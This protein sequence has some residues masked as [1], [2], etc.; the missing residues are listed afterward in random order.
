MLETLSGRLKGV[1]DKLRQRGSLTEADVDSALREIRLVLL[2]A[3][4]NFKVVKDFVAGVRERAVG[5]EV[6]GS[7]TPGQQVVKVVNDE[8]TKLLGGAAARMSFASKPPTVVMLV[9]LQG[10]GKTTATAKLANFVRGQGHNPRLVAAD[11]YRPAAVDQLASLAKELDVPITVPT[12][13]MKPLEVAKLGLK[14]AGDSAAD[15]IIVDTAGRTHIDEQ[16]M[17]EAAELKRELRP[18][19][20][21][22]VVDA[23]TGQ[24]AVKIAESFALHVDFDGIILTKLDGDARGGAALS[25]RAVTGKPVVFASVGEKMSSLEPFHPD[26]M[27]SR[28]LGMG[29]VLTLI[30][31]AQATVDEDKAREM[32]EKLRRAEF[33]FEDFLDQLGQVRKMG[34]MNELL[35]MIPGMNSKQLKGLAVDESQMNRIEAIIKSMTPKERLNPAIINGSRRGRIARGSGTDVHEVNQLLKQFAQT[36]KLMKQFADVGGKSKRGLRKSFP[37][38]G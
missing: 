36:K 12:A 20:V 9:G 22:L 35:G 1:L 27:A 37:F 14:E 8:L 15:T 19:Q 3:D 26:R 31:K 23:M 17:A 25:I 16:M 5:Q 6:L 2:E 28:I 10:S 32:E 18:H 4:V 11:I 30:E 33:T 29:D 34:P 7:L 38:L 13:G 21:L 24:D